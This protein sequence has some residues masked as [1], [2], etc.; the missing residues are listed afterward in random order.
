VKHSHDTAPASAVAATRLSVDSVGYLVDRHGDGRVHSAFRNACNV[1]F[2]DVIATVVTAGAGD[3][4][5]LLR[6]EYSSTVDLRAHFHPGER[7]VLECGLARFRHTIVDWSQARTW[8][9]PVARPRLDDAH[10]RGNVA[11]ARSSEAICRAQRPSIIA[12]LAQPVVRELEEAARHCDA[13]AAMPHLARL[14]GWGEGLTPAGDDFIV[15]WLAG[16]RAL[17]GSAM[18]RAAFIERIGD[19]IRAGL[20]ATTTL[21]AHMLRLASG[22]HFVDHLHALRAELLGAP[23]ASS[24][25]DALDR[26]L[27]VGASSGADTVSG[28]LSAFDAW[29]VHPSQQS[30]PS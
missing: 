13:A 29:L 22:G 20:D 5:T 1:V 28:L 19:R 7:C 12:T 23:S 17:A 14:I 3:G 6:L 24:L 4:P 21:S 10:I 11:L 26:A 18:R 8:R 27:A 16:L 25:L 2:G 15:G 9:A 30:R